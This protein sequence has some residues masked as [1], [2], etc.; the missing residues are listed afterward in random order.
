ME[1]TFPILN[2]Q[3]L[4]TAMTTRGSGWEKTTDQSANQ[5]IVSAGF[6]LFAWHL[7]NGLSRTAPTRTQRRFLYPQQT[8]LFSCYMFNLL[9]GDPLNL[10]FYFSTVCQHTD[11]TLCR[12]SESALKY[13]LLHTVVSL[14]IKGTDQWD[15]RPPVFSS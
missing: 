9:R 4:W 11:G 10:L 3:K 2:E 6:L 8:K 15:F 7:K 14:L 12:L 13:R 5:L 1:Y